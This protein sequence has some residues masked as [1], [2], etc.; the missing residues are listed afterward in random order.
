MLLQ[1]SNHLPISLTSRGIESCKQL[2]TMLN[3]LSESNDFREGDSHLFGYLY[4]T[5]D[6]NYTLNFDAK[7]PSI[8]PFETYKLPLRDKVVPNQYDS[9]VVL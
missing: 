8:Q 4:S 3:R 7:L 6:A 1:L 2:S 5:V 9:G